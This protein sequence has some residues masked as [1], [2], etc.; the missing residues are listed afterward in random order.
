LAPKNLAFAR[1][2]MALPQS[3]PPSPPGWYAYDTVEENCLSCKFL[4]QSNF[5]FLNIF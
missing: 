5:S 4:N 1:K 3:Q 2:I